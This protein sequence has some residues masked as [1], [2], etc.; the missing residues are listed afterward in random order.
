[1]SESKFNSDEI[2]RERRQASSKRKNVDYDQLEV[3]KQILIAAR[4]DSPEQFEARLKS[5]GID[6]NSARGLAAMQVYWTIR[7]AQR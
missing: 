6:P 3:R 7:R 2:E 4:T 1:M 5:F